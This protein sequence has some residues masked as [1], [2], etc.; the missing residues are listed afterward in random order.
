MRTAEV[1]V[2]GAGPVGLAIAL[3]LRLRGVA[4]HVL[5]TGPG[6]DGAVSG[7]VHH[8]S[9]LPGLERLG[10]LEDAVA[11][12]AVDPRWCLQV[13]RTGERIDFDLS[14]L[15]GEVRHPHHLYLPARDLSALLEQHLLRSG[16]V[17]ERD[18]RVL[19]LD[20]DRDGV[21][22][23][24]STPEG[25]A[26]RRADW[27]V[28]ADG[29]SSTVRRAA[30]LAFPGAS[31]GERCVVAEVELDETGLGYAPTTL[32]VDDRY[33]A[34][35]QKAGAGR[36]TYTCCEPLRLDEEGI[37]ERLGQVLAAAL[38]QRRVRV[39]D[40]AAA[41]MHQRC[42]DRYREGRLLLVGDAAH[43]TNR[44]TG[45]SS[46]GGMRDAEALVDALSAVLGGAADER[47]LDAYAEDRRRAFLDHALPTSAHRK[48]LVSQIQDPRRLEAELDQYREASADPERHRDLLL[49]TQELTSGSGARS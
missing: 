23:T 25:E 42:A 31:L 10:V 26:V 1:L 14:V 32:Q 35:V 9:V 4:V 21:A 45:Y 41:R 29:T 39:L 44:L 11:R 15:A 16:A 2:V 36:W 6:A 24:V 37:G 30:G 5:D 17:V 3:G 40:W 7:G 13:L 22:L 48:H 49:L 27:V 18:V 43:V 34:V 46:M 28:A 12:G 33:G 38:P 47:L 8:W 19:T 20:Q